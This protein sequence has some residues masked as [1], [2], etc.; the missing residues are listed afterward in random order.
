MNLPAKFRFIFILSGILISGLV[1]C[2][3]FG[4]QNI[5]I[6]EYTISIPVYGNSWLFND[7][8]R[9]D[10]IITEKGILNWKDTN[11]RIRIYF[12]VENKGLLNLALKVR[13]K[14]GQSILKATINA[15]SYEIRL[16]NTEPEALEVGAFQINKAGYQVLELQGLQKSSAEFAEITELLFGGEAVSGGVYFVK[17]DFYWGRRGPSVHL[18]YEI[19]PEAGDVCWFYNEMKIPEGN[20]ILGSYFMANGFA[21]G[22]FGIQVN[23][24][25]E[26]RILFSVWSPFKTDDPKAI[27]EDH[28]IKLLKKASDVYSGEFGNEGSGGQSY[29][30]FFWKAGIT[31]RFL[32]KAEPSVTNST[33]YTA[34]FFAPEI[35]KWELIASF[36]RPQTSTYL[37]RLHS[38]LENFIPEMGC[39]TRQVSYTNQWVCNAEGKWT[40][41]HRAK[42]TADAT[43]RKES[44]MD[45]AGGTN[46]QNFFLKNCGFFSEKV[47]FDTWFSRISS[48]KAPE[49]DFSKLP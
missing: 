14:S 1:S 5:P 30:K 28:R 21:E 35:G 31:Y 22:Y 29:R 46:E 43:A 37:K 6:A 18:N 10:E 8:M 41:L 33:D 19:P 12:R 20:D 2:G 39:V 15:Q 47:S 11:D 23:S 48:G 45:Y 9:S 26:R 36:R 4:M 7:L 32:L 16:K 49:I 44:R 13:V 24:E 38:F 27:P 34:W 3:A 25:T 17:D 40:E 42:F